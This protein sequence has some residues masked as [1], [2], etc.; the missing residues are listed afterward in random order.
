MDKGEDINRLLKNFKNVSINGKKPYANPVKN[1]KD[2]ESLPVIDKTIL[3][4]I[5][6]GIK[7]CPEKP[8]VIH[9]TSGSTNIPLVIHFSEQS[10][11]DIINRV[12]KGFE[13]AGLKKEDVVLNLFGYG[14]FVAGP[15]YD[16]AVKKAG[17][18]IMPLGSSNMTDRERLMRIL[19]KISPDVIF[20]VPSYSLEI[21]KMMKSENLNLPKKVLCAGEKLN[22]DY[23]KEFEKLGIKVFDNYGCTEVPAIS[24]EDDEKGWTRIIEEGIYAEFLND[25]GIPIE[26]GEGRLVLTDLHN[27]STPIIRYKLG[28]R[29][30]MKTKNG[31]KYIKILRRDD[32]LKKYRGFF[33]N[34][35]LL[36][37]EARK[38]SCDYFMSIDINKSTMK[39]ELEL[40]LPEKLSSKSEEIIRNFKEKHKVKP[41]IIFSDNIPAL[42]TASGKARYFIDKR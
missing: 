17:L 10:W 15:I 28:D 41:K 5:N 42:K 29:V 6:S 30:L 35:D 18:T 39:D 9:T 37:E 34:I 21:A 20:G 25:S 19:H 8:V 22:E 7:S 26:E 23:R 38:Y 16:S 4:C 40:Y 13:F 36:C 1:E 32:N 3:Q 14:T 27:F 11:N 24:A 33:I 31:R 2:F 12:I